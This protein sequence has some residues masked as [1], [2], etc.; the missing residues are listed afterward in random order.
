MELELETLLAARFPI[1]DRQYSKGTIFGDW[2]FE[3]GPG[4]L[5]L[6]ITLANKLNEMGVKPDNITVRQIKEKFWALRLYVDVP[7]YVDDEISALIDQLEQESSNICEACG[8]RKPSHMRR[9]ECDPARLS[10]D[11]QRTRFLT[12]LATG[13]G[14]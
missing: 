7:A 11:Y 6:F 3:C 2:G 1:Y 8:E 9:H 10:L 5:P 13:D 12:Q 14:V 4:W